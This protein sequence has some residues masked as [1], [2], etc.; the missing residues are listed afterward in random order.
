MCVEHLS[1]ITITFNQPLFLEGVFMQCL[2][3]QICIC[4]T[5]D[6]LFDRIALPQ[7]VW[8]SPWQR[9][10]L[11]CLTGQHTFLILCS[12]WRKGMTACPL[13]VSLQNFEHYQTSK[14]KCFSMWCHQIWYVRGLTFKMQSE[15]FAISRVSSGWTPNGLC[16]LPRRL[17][18]WLTH[19]CEL[20]ATVS[21]WDTPS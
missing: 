3:P 13:N 6:R 17:I 12:A 9:I 4:P 11:S 1:H 20:R 21:F 7:R 10:P 18:E 5:F 19:A 14:I 8:R 15:S 2:I 16:G